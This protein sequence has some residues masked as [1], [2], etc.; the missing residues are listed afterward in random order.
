MAREGSRTSLPL[1]FPL[2]LRGV[3]AAKTPPMPIL[4]R[5]QCSSARLH[6]TRSS[7]R[8]HDVG[9]GPWLFIQGVALPTTGHLRATTVHQGGSAVS[10][11]V[12]A[13]GSAPPGTDKLISISLRVE[14]GCGLRNRWCL[15]TRPH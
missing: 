12:R 13:A 2:G 5:G 8:A 6:T 10:P 9:A 14:A 3:V 1:K 4:A 7:S 11:L 15:T